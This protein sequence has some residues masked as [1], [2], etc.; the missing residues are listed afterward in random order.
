MAATSHF[1]EGRVRDARDVSS[2]VRMIEIEPSRGARPYPTGA[3]LDIAVIIDELPDI[4]SYSLVGERPV[5]GAYRIAVKAVPQSRGGSVYVRGLRPG[6]RV[7]IS[8]PSSARSTPT[9]TRT[10]PTSTSTAAR[11]GP[12]A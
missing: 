1:S 8:R 12:A 11:C 6:A 3:H 5:D 7:M 9:R 4:R 2:D 10:S